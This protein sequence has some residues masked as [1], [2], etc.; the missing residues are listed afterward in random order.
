MTSYTQM[1]QAFLASKSGDSYQADLPETMETG[2]HGIW[3][4]NLGALIGRDFE[5]S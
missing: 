4:S 5:R 2:A 1:M 3:R